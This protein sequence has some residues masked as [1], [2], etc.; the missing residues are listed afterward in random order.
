MAAQG[1]SSLG[2]GI[3]TLWRGKPRPPAKAVKVDLAEVRA[4]AIEEARLRGVDIDVDGLIEAAVA[5]RGVLDARTRV[6][7]ALALAEEGLSD[8]SRGKATD[9]TG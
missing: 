5:D 9:R 6:G 1:Y 7:A 8:G 4:R 3:A 2:E